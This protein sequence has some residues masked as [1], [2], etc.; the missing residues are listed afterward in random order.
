MGDVVGLDELRRARKAEQLAELD[1]RGVRFG[2]LVGLGELFVGVVLRHLGEL[3]LPAFLGDDEPALFAGHLRQPLLDELV[4]RRGAVQDDLGR[5]IAVNGIVALQHFGAGVFEGLVQFGEV[6]LT[7][8]EPSVVD[9]KDVETDAVV[10]PRKGEDVLGVGAGQD[11]LLLFRH[12]ADGIDPVP[13]LGGPF[14]LEVLRVVF[15]TDFEQFDVLLR[16]AALHFP[17]EEFDG[18]ID[19]RVVVLEGDLPAAGRAALADVIPQAGPHVRAGARE[20]PVAVRE[21]EDLQCGIH[22]LADDEPGEVRSDVLRVLFLLLFDILD[23]PPLFVRDLHVPVALVVLQKDVV[24]RHVLLD[25]AALEDE[26]LEL[27][28]AEDVV[29]VPDVFHH[30]ADLRRVVVLR[31]EVLADPVLQDLRLADVDD[32]ALP[33]LHD[34][35]AGDQG[36]PHRLG[37]EFFHLRVLHVLHLPFS[38]L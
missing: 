1:D 18:F 21:F 24:L 20:R 36:Q 3:E 14:E 23:A 12:A 27:A 32:F 16:A 13:H 25:E 5:Y 4:V 22:R 33:V 30:A 38:L 31:A 17:F 8:G 34:V 29:E 6:G 19:R 7:G 15:H 28:A 11:D 2:A 26:R 35:D 37:P 9:A 10:L